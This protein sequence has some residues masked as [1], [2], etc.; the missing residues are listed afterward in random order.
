MCV[1]TVHRTLYF[2]EEES[3][4]VEECVTACMCA[5]A[6][7]YTHTWPLEM[8]KFVDVEDEKKLK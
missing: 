5:F 2:K 1:W 8:F 3:D 7:S 6:G 4:R